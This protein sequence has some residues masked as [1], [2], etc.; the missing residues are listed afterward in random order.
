VWVGGKLE[1]TVETPTEEHAGSESVDAKSGT[2]VL[3]LLPEAP[4]PAE[5]CIL[6]AGN[7]E[8]F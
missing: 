3:S 1:P 6:G 4:T 2:T 7:S 5:P 8:D